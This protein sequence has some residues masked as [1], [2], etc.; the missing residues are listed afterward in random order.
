MKWSVLGLVVMG[1]AAA[2]CCALLVATLRGGRAIGDVVEQ[3]PRE[4]IVLVAGKEVPA[5]SVMSADMVETK[6]VT[7]QTA[8]PGY[9]VDSTQVVGKVITVPLEAGEPITKSCF[10]ASGPGVNVAAKLPEGMR[11][12]SIALADY[13]SLDGLL[14]PGSVVDVIASFRLPSNS[15]AGGQ[16]VSITLLQGVQVLAIENQTVGT[17]L[18]ETKQPKVM[19]SRSQRRKVTVMVDSRQAKALQLAMEHGKVSLALRNPFDMDP[20][21]VDATLLNEGR[22]ARLAEFLKPTPAEGAE[23][24]PAPVQSSP[25]TSK[26][27]ALGD[28]EPWEVHIHRGSKVETHK[29]KRPSDK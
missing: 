5:M 22:L 16:A 29:F 21:E 26:K 18:K 13:A 2:F 23:P 7:M 19:A 3:Q 6:K 28:D 24:A 17:D 8:P 11:A 15:K 1:A 10:V 27:D 14:Y 9:L 25:A 4:V 20:V 12:I